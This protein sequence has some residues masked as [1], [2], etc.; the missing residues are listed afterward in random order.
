[1]KLLDALHW[2]YA[3]K[4]MNGQKVEE[5]VVNEIIE[6]I[7]LTPSSFGLQPYSL[8]VITDPELKKQLLAASWNQSQ[9]VDCSHLLVFANWTT[10]TTEQIEGFIADV[11]EQRNIPIESLNDY[12]KMVVNTVSSKSKEELSVWTS[13]QTYIALGFGLI[14][15]A[16]AGID[17][18][19]MEGFMPSK[20]NEILQLT[21]KGLNASVILPIGFRDENDKYALVQKVRRPSKH[22]IVN[23]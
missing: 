6:A 9:I 15:A 23:K 1:M 12:K 21:D 11:A 18:T 13:K 3:T 22:F 8:F 7:R 4:K 5:S 20:Y 2:R 19:P 17:S 14:A 16:I 10:V